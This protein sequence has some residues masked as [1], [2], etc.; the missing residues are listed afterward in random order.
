VNGDPG[1]APANGRYQASWNS[2]NNPHT[3]T[4]FRIQSVN[5][6]GFMQVRVN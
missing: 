1:Y 2:A 5:A 6:N 3:G 4:T